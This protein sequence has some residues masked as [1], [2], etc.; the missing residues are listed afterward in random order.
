MVP[1]GSTGAT[2]CGTHGFNWC[3]PLWHQLVQLGPAIM[4][5]IGLVGVPPIAV[6]IASLVVPMVAPIG[7][8]GATNWLS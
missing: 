5:P 3:Q 6:P 4:T 1:T 2:H 8:V 7:L